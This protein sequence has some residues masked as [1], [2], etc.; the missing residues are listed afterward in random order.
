[1]SRKIAKGLWISEDL[2]REFDEE[3]ERLSLLM[4]ER[5]EAGHVGAAAL[6]AF[7][8]LP[9]DRQKLQAIRAAKNYTL[10]RVIETLPHTRGESDQSKGGMQRAGG[11]HGSKAATREP[12]LK[13]M[14][15]R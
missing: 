3:V 11:R 12:P 14:A 15:N 6:L 7:L 2:A 1:M 4:P 8:R 13:A 10:D 9:D 5:L